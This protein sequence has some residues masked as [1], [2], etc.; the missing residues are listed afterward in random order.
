[1]KNCIL[2][3]IFIGLCR[4]LSAQSIT[5]FET[6]G[7]PVDTVLNG[8]NANGSF[9][10]G[11]LEL[12]NTFT[13]FPNFE[14]WEGWSISTWT[15]TVTV[16]F[17]NQYSSISGSGHDGSSTFAVC[18]IPVPPT[19]PTVL[20]LTDIAA[21][22]QVMGM[23]VNNNTYAY[24]SMRDGDTPPGPGKK[25]GGVSGDDPDYFLLSIRK[26]KDGVLSTDSVAF[27][28]ADFRST[29]NSQDYIIKD[30]TY[31]D[32]TALGDVD[33]LAFLLTSSDN[34]GFGMNTPA[35]F[36]VDDVITSN[37]TTDIL[38]PDMSSVR[39]F[40]NP[41]KDLLYIQGMRPEMHTIRV[42]ALTGQVLLREEVFGERCQLNLGDLPS[43]YYSIE[44][45][46]NSG[47]QL[48]KWAKQ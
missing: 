17:T 2:I 15:D 40:P 36:C 29:D 16:G 34:G 21:G 8:K 14:A 19:K 32:L 44:I 41:G 43:G 10:T 38:N 35:Y 31:V 9:T 26:Y 3:T 45:S 46:S 23:Y 33:S 42:Q 30:W 20:K 7:L 12:P 28:L 25:F 24:L 48:V 13:V 4:L 37:F 5:D 27:Y 1:M 11:K 6:F 22:K 18:Y 47:K 39:A